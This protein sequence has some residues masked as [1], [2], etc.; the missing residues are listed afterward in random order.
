LARQVAQWRE[1]Q[2]SMTGALIWLS[3]IA[4]TVTLVLVVFSLRQMVARSKGV[5]RAVVATIIFSLIT[6]ALTIV[7]LVASL[8]QL[9]LF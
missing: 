7:S 8:Q 6:S 9:G 2:F 3:I 1:E 5:S 4:A